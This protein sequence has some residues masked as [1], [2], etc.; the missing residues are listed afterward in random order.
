MTDRADDKQ[1]PPSYLHLLQLQQISIDLGQQ[2]RAIA[3]SP[4]R[5]V[6]AEAGCLPPGPLTLLAD[7]PKESHESGLSGVLWIGRSFSHVIQASF[8]VRRPRS[9][10]GLRHRP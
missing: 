9:L 1:E 3:I 5:L 7:I 2:F 8:A 10:L 6:A 4:M